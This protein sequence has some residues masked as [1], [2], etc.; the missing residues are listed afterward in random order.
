MVIYKT[1]PWPSPAGSLP[2][3]VCGWTDGLMEGGSGELQQPYGASKAAS[4][5]RSAGKGKSISVQ[6]K[7]NLFGQ[8][9]SHCLIIYCHRQAGSLKREAFLFI[10]G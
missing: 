7:T 4:W 5:P 9:A 3:G 8:F 1:L 6:A 10:I 2:V